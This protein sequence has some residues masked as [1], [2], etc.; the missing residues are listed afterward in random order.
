MKLIVGLGNPEKEFE[1][2]P[3]NAGYFFV[4]NFPKKRFK[5]VI[6]KRSESFMNESGLCV[7]RLMGKYG[8]DPS[9]LYVVHDDLD[10]RLGEFK[11]QFG[12][13]PKDHNGIKSVNNVL[14]TNQYW[15]IRIGVDNRSLEKR[16]PGKIY[17]LQ[18]FTNDEKE[19]LGNTINEAISDLIRRLNEK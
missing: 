8:I 13:G 9:D 5:D 1:N 4:D 6:V 12:K 11:I 17:V 19:Q 3:H 7:D 2:T 16:T 10:I 15:H 18:D 14:G